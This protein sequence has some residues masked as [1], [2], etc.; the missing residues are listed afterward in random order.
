MQEALEEAKIAFEKDEVPVGAIIVKNSQIIARAHNQ[1]I[2]QTDPTAHAEI[3]AIRAA[4][5]ALNSSRLDDCDLY[6][7]LEPC[8]MCTTAIALSRINRL[9]FSCHDQKFGAIESNLQIFNSNLSL[10]KP[11][12][13]SGFFESESKQLLKDFFQ[14]KR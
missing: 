2:A 8:P 7:T 13:Y 6:V 11:E 3:L 1:N 14:S 12:I 10:H 9:Y 4:A 5:K